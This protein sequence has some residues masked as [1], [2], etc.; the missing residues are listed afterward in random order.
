MGL[1]TDACIIS[2]GWDAAHSGDVLHRNCLSPGPSSPVKFHMSR[3]RFPGALAKKPGSSGMSG[4]YLGE[5]LT[6]DRNAR[7]FGIRMPKVAGPQAPSDSAEFPPSPVGGVLARHRHVPGNLHPAGQPDI[8]DS[9]GLCVCHHVPHL[10]I[11]FPEDTLAVGH[12]GALPAPLRGAF[13]GQG[14]ADP[15]GCVDP[16]VRVLGCRR[17]YVLPCRQL[18]QVIWTLH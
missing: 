2:P 4:L 5:T 14:E 16:P 18:P 15:A 13:W 1:S 3:G 6:W 8:P 7:G 11:L 17:P 9:P 12:R 10:H